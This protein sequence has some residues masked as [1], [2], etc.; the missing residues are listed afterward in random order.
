MQRS[1][2]PSIASCFSHET[3]IVYSFGTY[4]TTLHHYILL[5]NFRTFYNLLELHYLED[6]V[7]KKLNTCLFLNLLK[8]IF[9][10][11]IVMKF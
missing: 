10:N 8:C 4:Y 1:P 7:K 6:V 5:Q 9:E 2:L 3:C 11:K